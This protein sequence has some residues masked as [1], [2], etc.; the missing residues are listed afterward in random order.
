ME[1]R[2]SHIAHL[3]SA[4]AAL[5]LQNVARVVTYVVNPAHCFTIVNFV[6][7]QVDQDVL[8][9]CRFLHLSLRFVIWT[10]P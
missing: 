1:G 5:A 9:Y 6:T 3:V 4:I 7:L 10:F 2:I 8:F